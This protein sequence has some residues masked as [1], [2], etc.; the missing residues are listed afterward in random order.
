MRRNHNKICA[1]N[2]EGGYMKIKTINIKSK[3]MRASF[4]AFI[5]VLSVTAVTPSASAA[6]VPNRYQCSNW[7]Q[8]CVQINGAH[9]PSLPNSCRMVWNWYGSGPS[10]SI[11]N[12]WW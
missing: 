10:T 11:C 5:A 1:M 2:N 6:S 12:S 7:T 9:N 4:V 3:I 8:K